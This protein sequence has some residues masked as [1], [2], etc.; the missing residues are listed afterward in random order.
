MIRHEGRFPSRLANDLRGFYQGC[1]NLWAT[2]GIAGGA[3]SQGR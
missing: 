1:D 2:V 3:E